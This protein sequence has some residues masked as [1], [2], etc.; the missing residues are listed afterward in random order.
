MQDSSIQWM[1]VGIFDIGLTTVVA[2]HGVCLATD[3]LAGDFIERGLLVK[4]FDI[5]MTSGVQVNLLNLCF[6]PNSP[7]EE[8]IMAFTN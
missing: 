8:R 5:G 4:P 3:S 2:G 7:K 1:E 6:A